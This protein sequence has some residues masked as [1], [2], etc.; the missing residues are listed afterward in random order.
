MTKTILILAIAAAFVAGTIT[1]TGLVYAHGGD[2][3]LIH[4]CITKSSGSTRILL[5]PFDTCK[6]NEDPVHW[7]IVGPAGATGPAGP[8]GPTGPPGPIGNIE[9]EPPGTDIPIST[10]GP[11]VT[12]D[13]PPDMVMTGFDVSISSTLDFI[14]HCTPLA[15]VP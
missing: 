6:A 11:L 3:T 1:T 7:G 8:E 2:I 9:Q 15:I 10:T 4:A 14:V 5:N 13:C 12:A